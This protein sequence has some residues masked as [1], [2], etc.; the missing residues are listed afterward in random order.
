D[1]ASAEW[2]FVV[3]PD[4]LALRQGPTSAG[5]SSPDPTVVAYPLDDPDRLA[6]RLALDLQKVFK[7]QSVWRIA[8]ECAGAPGTGAGPALALD[9]H[10]LDGP[11]DREGTP[12]AGRVLHPGDWIEIRLRNAGPEALWVTLLYLDPN[13]GISEAPVGS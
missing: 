8:G 12:L 4:R 2:R 10:L 6:A 9:I 11:D 13:F 7:W 5:T 1:P 3:E